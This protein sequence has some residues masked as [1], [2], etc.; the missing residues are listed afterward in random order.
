LEDLRVDV[1]IKLKYILKK[2][3]VS[4]WIEFIS[5]FTTG[6]FFVLKGPIAEATD[7]PQP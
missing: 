2:L 5:L 4:Q 1:K 7:A 6:I 3:T